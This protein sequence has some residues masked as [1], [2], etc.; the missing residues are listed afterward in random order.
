[1]NFCIFKGKFANKNEEL[2]CQN[3]FFIC[4]STKKHTEIHPVVYNWISNS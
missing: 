1:V 4:F 3:S 2:A